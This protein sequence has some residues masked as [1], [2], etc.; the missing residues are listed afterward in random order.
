MT[1]MN[2]NDFGGWSTQGRLRD[3]GLL[4]PRNRGREG[5]SM[6]CPAA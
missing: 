6:L 4:S 3:L 1:W 2:S 5:V